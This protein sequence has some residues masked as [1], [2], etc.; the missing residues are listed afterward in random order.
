MPGNVAAVYVAFL[1]LSTGWKTKCFNVG[2]VSAVSPGSQHAHQSNLTA[3]PN[4]H[5]WHCLANKAP[6]QPVSVSQFHSKN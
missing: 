4:I 5:H 3:C 6:E 1:T 2:W